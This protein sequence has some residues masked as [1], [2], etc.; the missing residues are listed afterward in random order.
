[1]LFVKNNPTGR[2]FTPKKKKPPDPT[3]RN[4]GAGHGYVAITGV[5]KSVDR[6]RVKN[7]KI[8]VSRK[9]QMPHYGAQCH[10]TF[11]SSGSGKKHASCIFAKIPF[12]ILFFIF[13][14]RLTTLDV[15]PRSQCK[16]TCA[17]YACVP[18]CSWSHFPDGTLD[19]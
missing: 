3:R 12:K 13:P 1:M 6:I 9:W 16:F 8:Q 14:L 7:W 19:I 18:R 17:T 11:H 10:R 2:M 15:T 5:K 4:E